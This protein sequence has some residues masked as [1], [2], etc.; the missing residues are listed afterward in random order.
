MRWR[1]WRPSRPRGTR[2]GRRL[3]P[4]RR[5]RP[6]RR[7]EGRP[8]P[9]RRRSPRRRHRS[10]GQRRRWPRPPRLRSPAWSSPARDREAGPR[11]FRPARGHT[12][13]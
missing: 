13:R 8:R 2:V 9:S 6:A 7:G 11:G 5:G 10:L 12:S 1:S 3:K 4:T